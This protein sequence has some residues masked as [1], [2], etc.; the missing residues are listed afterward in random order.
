MISLLINFSGFYHFQL[1]A[2]RG[3]ISLS[4]SSSFLLLTI[5]N[6][7]VHKASAVTQPCDTASIS[8]SRSDLEKRQTQVFVLRE[9]N[10]F[11]LT[12]MKHF[13]QA[14]TEGSDFMEPNT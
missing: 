2:V 13:I 6:D 5:S 8:P 14:P 9:D 1:E 4:L 10:S 12:K 3:R 11:N 7:S